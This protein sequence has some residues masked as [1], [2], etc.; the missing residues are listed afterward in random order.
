VLTGLIVIAI[1]PHMLGQNA[2]VCA[3]LVVEPM[4]GS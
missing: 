2:A 3:R 1:C 4:D